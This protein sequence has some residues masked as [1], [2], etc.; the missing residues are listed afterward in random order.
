M[1]YP[2]FT[3]HSLMPF[4]KHKDKAMINIPAVYLLW[5]YDN[6]CQH[7]GVKGYIEDNMDAL[8]QEAKKAVRK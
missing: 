8:K 3:D 1:S 5:L 7:P 6:G 2:R 4:G